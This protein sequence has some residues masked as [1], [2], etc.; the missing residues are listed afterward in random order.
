MKTGFI[1]FRKME[2][3]DVLKVGTRRTREEAEQFI[4]VLRQWWPAEYF[5][6]DALRIG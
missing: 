2:Q 3:G 4:V 6:E 5:I 1:V